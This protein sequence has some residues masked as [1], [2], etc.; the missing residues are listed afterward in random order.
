M[1]NNLLYLL[2]SF[3]K[4]SDIKI[5]SDELKVQLLSH[6]SYPSLHS[7]TGVLNHFNIP[8]VAVSLPIEAQILDELTPVFI[9]QIQS[10][11]V[12]DLVLVKKNSDTYDLIYSE[13]QKESLSKDNFLQKFLGIVVVVEKEDV[14][15]KAPVNQNL[16]DYAFVSVIL[17]ILFIQFF[18]NGPS[19]SNAAYILLSLIGLIVSFA[20]FKQEQ[21]ETTIVGNAFCNSSDEKK[22]CNSVLNS[23][24]ANIFKNFKLSDAC[25]IYFVASIIG[26][27]LFQIQHISYSLIYGISFLALPVTFYSIYYQ[28][29]V[30][31]NWCALCLAIV[32]V[33]WAQ[34][35]S[36]FLNNDLEF[37][38]G[39]NGTLVLLVAYLS[40]VFV[41]SYVRRL[42]ESKKKLFELNIEFLRFKRNFNLFKSA[43]LRSDVIDT[44]IPSIDE[45]K[46]GNA[47]SNLKIV[48]VTNPFCGHCAAVHTLIEDILKKY[49]ESVEIRVRFNV[50]ANKVDDLGVI[51][52]TRIMELYDV[53]GEEKSLNA[54]HDIY[55]EMKAEAW[56]EKWGRCKH[57]DGYHTV[58]QKKREWCM[59]KTL[60]FTPVILINGREYPRAY[61]RKDL[62]HFME[63]L[64]EESQEAL[65]L[66][67]SMQ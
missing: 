11:G 16:K 51:I 9:A 25:I 3:L 22:D 38:I 42:I 31:K 44:H 67:D 45:I 49:N 53:L 36:F 24:A 26:A 66:E 58:L 6:P 29:F 35:G 37:S 52:A 55:G 14:M 2:N 30:L 8:N 40:I 48:V 43:L 13:G 12:K 54:M 39:F 5:D 33:L 28:K 50:N 19:Y 23:K 41:W 63:E 32:V 20:I 21:G 15:V 64:E 7:L 61:D 18:A 56:I 47:T 46:F 4:A 60:N 65:E 17:I 62:I 1:R 34:A 10:D 59:S 27:Y 57:L